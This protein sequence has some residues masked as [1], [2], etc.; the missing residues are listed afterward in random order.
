MIMEIINLGH[1]SFLIKGENISV[2]TDPYRNR[3]VPNLKM[4][5]VQAN[6]VTVSHDHYDHD[7]KNLVTIIPTDREL[8]FEEILVA[9][10]HHNGAHRGLNK[11][12][13]FEIDGL[14]ILHTGD[15]GCIPLRNILEQMTNVDILLAPING[16]FTI[17]AEELKAIMDVTNPRV[18]IP[19]HYYKKEDNSGYPDGGQIDIFKKLVGE[20]LEVEDRITVNDELFK[21][22]VVIFN[23]AVQE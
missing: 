7:A 14:R 21:N 8:K 12:Y 23:K 16:H 20:Y 15:L 17:S 19:M 22:R 9:H 3:S 18:T 13:L 1:A 10:D 5:R 11:M 6:F 2:V 4:P